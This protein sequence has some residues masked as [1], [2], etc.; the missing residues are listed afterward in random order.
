MNDGW[1]NSGQTPSIIIKEQIFVVVA[2]ERGDWNL[3]VKL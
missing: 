1:I 2:D 3:E